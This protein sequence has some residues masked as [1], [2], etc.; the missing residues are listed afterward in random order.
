MWLRTALEIFKRLDKRV[1]QGKAP[2]VVAAA[3]AYL[4]A[5]RLGLYVRTQAIAK[6]LNVSKYSVR[7]TAW[8]LRRYMQKE[9][10]ARI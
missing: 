10:A 7:D 8:R 3:L 1:Y 9:E 4:A 5:E 2:R 6:I